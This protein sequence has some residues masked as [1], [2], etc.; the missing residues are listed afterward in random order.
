M[1]L[2]IDDVY[3][4][5]YKNKSEWRKVLLLTEMLYVGDKGLTVSPPP[6]S[7]TEYE[8]Y[9]CNLDI[10]LR[11]PNDNRYY[12]DVDDALSAYVNDYHSP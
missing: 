8:Q 12:K 1:P 5:A 6:S 11:Y 4:A 2:T 7:D 3:K 9:K 10:L